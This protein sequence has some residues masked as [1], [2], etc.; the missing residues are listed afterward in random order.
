MRLPCVLEIGDESR[1]TRDKSWFEN[2]SLVGL[3]NRI[4]HRWNWHGDLIA[5]ILILDHKSIRPSQIFGDGR[6]E[7]LIWRISSDP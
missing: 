3:N 2:F 1:G 6:R 4:D 5:E 7:N